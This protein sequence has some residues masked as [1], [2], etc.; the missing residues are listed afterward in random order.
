MPEMTTS[1]HII[2]EALA[3]PATDRLEVIEQLWD[4]L[5]AEPQ[6]LEM[7]DAQRQELD[8]RIEQMDADPKAGIPWQDVKADL[9]N[10]R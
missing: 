6:S 4:S 3:L 1:K 2:S 9:R 10:Q 8:R 7:T 5:A